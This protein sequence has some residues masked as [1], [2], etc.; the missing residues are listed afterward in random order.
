MTRFG[1]LLGGKK[2]EEVVGSPIVEEDTTNYEAV[3]EEE[4]EED[5]SLKVI[6]TLGEIIMQEQ[7]DVSDNKIDLS[8][9]D[10]GIYYLEIVSI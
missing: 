4:M 5:A 2:V 9:Y 8:A 1:D 7:L 3:I 10:K 6:N